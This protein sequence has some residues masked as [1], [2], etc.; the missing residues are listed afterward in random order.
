MLKEKLN[1]KIINETV[2]TI[3]DSIYEVTQE[4]MYESNQY[5]ESNDKFVED[6]EKYV[7]EVIKELNNRIK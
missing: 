3:I 7:I 2:E 1:K 5:N 4:Y 6:Q